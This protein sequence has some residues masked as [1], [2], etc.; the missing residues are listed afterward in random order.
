MKKVL[1]VTSCTRYVR[2]LCYASMNFWKVSRLDDPCLAPLE[3][4][5]NHYDFV[6]FDL[7][8]TGLYAPDLLYRITGVPG[9]P[10]VFILSREMCYAFCCLAR[11]AG[12]CGYFL[13][14]YHISSLKRKIDRFFEAAGMAE[15]AEPCMADDSVLGNLIIGQSPPMRKLRMEI[16]AFRLHTEPVL[17]HG[18]TGSGKEL[19]A[20]AIHENSPVASGPYRSWNASCITASLAESILFGTVQGSYTGAADSRGL[21]E[22]A[23]RGTLFMDEIGELDPVLQPKFLRVLE[24]KQVQRVGASRFVKVDFRLVCA[25]N[26]RMHESVAAGFFREDLYHRLDVLRLEIPPLRDHLEDIPSLVSGRLKNYGKVL[27]NNALEKLNECPW[28]GNVRQLYNC[29]ARAACS[30]PGDVIY[31]DQIQF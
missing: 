14:P 5:S 7:G 26:R 11:K 24:D 31:P 8:L 29:L 3:I 13:I 20:R 9:H 17:I 2:E 15:N 12:V 21:F 25:S 4:T 22:S 18:E 27:S 6:F 10:P 19:A 16:L 1:F 30:S 28:P 23:D